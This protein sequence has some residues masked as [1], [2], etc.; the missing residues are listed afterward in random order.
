MVSDLKFF[1]QKWFKID[2]AKKF[3]FLHFFYFSFTFEV[4]FK[5]F[6]ATFSEVGCPKFLEIWNLWGKSN[7]KKWSWV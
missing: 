7:G 3:F 4:P 6:F 5:H 2:A 1:A